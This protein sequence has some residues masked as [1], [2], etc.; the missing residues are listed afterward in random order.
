MIERTIDPDDLRAFRIQLSEEGRRVMRLSLPIH[1]AFL[2]NLT[3]DMNPA[4]IAQL[5]SLL[6]KLHH[7]LLR[8]AENECTTRRNHRNRRRTHN[9][10]TAIQR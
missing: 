2:N 7:S 9:V 6:E 3:N 1:I 4:E 5:E 8:G 10:Q